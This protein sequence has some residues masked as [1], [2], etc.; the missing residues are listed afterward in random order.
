M[1][2]TIALLLCVALSFAIIACGGNDDDEYNGGYVNYPQNNNTAHNT[3]VV[4]DVV[5]KD[6]GFVNNYGMYTWVEVDEFSFEDA[7]PHSVFKTSGTD[8]TKHY[9]YS[10]R[11][12]VCYDRISWETGDTYDDFTRNINETYAYT[13]L[14]N[15]SI[16]VNDKT[17]TI[18]DRVVSPTGNVVLKV[19]LAAKERLFVL[20][21]QIDWEKSPQA[22]DGRADSEIEKSHEI[23]YHYIYYFKK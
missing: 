8:D 17:W 4:T 11:E 1:K 13:V 20:S 7:E 15:D 2:K 22:V 19:K 9:I 10:F 12:G 6:Y 16:L 5:P 14:N 3:S 21:E 18:I 23:Y